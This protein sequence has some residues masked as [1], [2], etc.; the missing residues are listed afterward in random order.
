MSGPAPVAALL[1]LVTN[2]ATPLTAPLAGRVPSANKV[3]AGWA[4][5]GL[6]VLAIIAVALLC[7]SFVRQLR[8]TQRNAE[9]GVFGKE[10]QDKALAEREAREELE[11]E[12]RDEAPGGVE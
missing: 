1:A 5:F 4:A 8:K 10:A 6:F 11:A 9:E 12:G 3:V 2:L 7:W